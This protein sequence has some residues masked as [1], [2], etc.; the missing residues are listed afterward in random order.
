MTNNASCLQ[1]C[2]PPLLLPPLPRP[3]LPPTVLALD[4]AALHFNVEDSGEPGSR[5]RNHLPSLCQRWV[6]SV[7]Q[8]PRDFVA[9]NLSHRRIYTGGAD[10]LVRL[11]DPELG[12]DQEPPSA[13]EAA[14]EVTTVASGVRQLMC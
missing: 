2:L 12:E 11:W 7:N 14:D 1:S 10:S 8:F 3:A 9:P 4:L 6:V 5:A 13:A